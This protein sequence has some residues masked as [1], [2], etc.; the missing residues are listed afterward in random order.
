MWRPEE[1]PGK[2]LK[3]VQDDDAVFSELRRSVFRMT[4]LCFQDDGAVFSG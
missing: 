1:R 4:A 2:I 3:Q